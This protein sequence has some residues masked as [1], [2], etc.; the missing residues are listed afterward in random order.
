MRVRKYV[1]SALKD[2]IWIFVKSFPFLFLSLLSLFLSL[3]SLSLSLSLSLSFSLSHFPTVSVYLYVCFSSYIF[4]FRH[5][6]VF[7]DDLSTVLKLLAQLQILIALRLLS[8]NFRAPSQIAIVRLS[9]YLSIAA[10][11]LTFAFD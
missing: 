10:V 8:L 2:P 1:F 4:R 11:V 3:P 7:A 5:T 9:A 6:T